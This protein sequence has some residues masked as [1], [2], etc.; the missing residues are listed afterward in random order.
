MDRVGD[1]IHSQE[2]ELN[3]NFMLQQEAKFVDNSA[4]RM[5]DS[6]DGG[7]TLLLVPAKRKI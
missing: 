2:Q 4:F 6:Q 7:E 5:L 1:E 3:S